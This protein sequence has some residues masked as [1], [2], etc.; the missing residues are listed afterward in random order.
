[1]DGETLFE[2]PIYSMSEEKFKKRWAKKREQLYDEFI[3]HGHTKECAMQIVSN[4]YNKQWQWRYNQIIGYIRISVTKLDVLLD[5]YCIICDRLY[6]DSSK[7]QYIVDWCPNGM[8]FNILRKTNNEIKE[9]ILCL[10]QSVEKVH[11]KG[12]YYVDYSTF[13]NIFNS[14]NIR[15]II[16]KL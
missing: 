16:E 5:L 1:M 13:N 9:G 12:R 11:L 10:L 15:E 2:I 4:Y 6:V 7:K 14:I 8:H 3:N